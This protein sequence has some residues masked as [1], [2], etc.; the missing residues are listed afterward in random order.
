MNEIFLPIVMFICV[1]SGY[2]ISRM[3]HEELKELK[4]A[5]RIG[6]VLLAALTFGTAVYFNFIL[7]IVV[8][9]LSIFLFYFSKNDYFIHRI[10]LFGAG[11]LLFF[12]EHI[13]VYSCFVML[14]II[15]I[16]SNTYLKNKKNFL[17][18]ALIYLYFFIPAMIVFII[19]FLFGGVV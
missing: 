10:F 1:V 12:V 7:S 3:A 8:F 19:K 11:L 16:I 9:I 15:F 18:N 4:T 5:L 14:G 13:F 17:K 6:F 2:F